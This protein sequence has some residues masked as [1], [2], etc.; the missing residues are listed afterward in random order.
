MFSMSFPAICAEV[1]CWPQH[2]G[3]GAAKL[4]YRHLKAVV[5]E[6]GSIKLNS[7][8]CNEVKTG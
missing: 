8:L 7:H 3:G 4:E 5:T 2:M 1:R 6:A